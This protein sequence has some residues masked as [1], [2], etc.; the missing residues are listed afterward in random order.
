M[1]SNKIKKLLEDITK[2]SRFPERDLPWEDIINFYSI[3]GNGFESEEIELVFK[4]K[5]NPDG[6][7]AISSE[8]AIQALLEL[9]RKPEFL[10]KLHTESKCL[11][12]KNGGTIHHG[13]DFK[14]MLQQLGEDL[15]ENDYDDF[16]REALGRSDDTFD[17]N[18]FISFMS[19]H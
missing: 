4:K 15:S 5:Y 17:I 1:S 11:D 18:E 19:K 6:N 7:S 12:R 16:I 9:I 8:K 10:L 14:F 3:F 13:A 2:I